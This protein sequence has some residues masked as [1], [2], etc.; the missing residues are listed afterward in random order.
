[1]GL[2]V[3]LQDRLVATC[4]LGDGPEAAARGSNVATHATFPI[5]W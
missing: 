1:M 3:T 5:V 2:D 4:R